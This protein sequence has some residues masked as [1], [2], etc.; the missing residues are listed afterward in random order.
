MDIE[1]LLNPADESIIIDDATDAEIYQAVMD[2]RNA[3]EQALINGGDDDADDSSPDEP[4]PTCREVLAAVSVLKN[5]IDLESDPLARKIDALLDS[6]KYN[7]HIEQ[8]KS[9]QPTHI[10][11]YFSRTT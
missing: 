1:G 8:S 3:Q 9:M 6:F 7:L 10:T 2:A 11:G 5:Y 4:S